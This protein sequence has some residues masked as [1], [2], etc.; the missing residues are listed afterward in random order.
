MHSRS[1]I[2]RFQSEAEE[3]RFWDTHDT[4]EF[5]GELKPARVTFLPPKPKVLVS[6][7]I[8]KGE[9]ALLRRV[10]ARKGLGYGP[11]IRMWLRERLIEELEVTR[12]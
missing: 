4:T 12:K 1:K 11:L 3:A 10:A 9:V 5:L 7:R 8:A 6:V 2:P